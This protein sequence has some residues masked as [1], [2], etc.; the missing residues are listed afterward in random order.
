MEGAKIL[1]RVSSHQGVKKVWIGPGETVQRLKC[2][3]SAELGISAE[4]QDLCVVNRGDGPS[5][6]VRLDRMDATLGEMR[7]LHGDMVYLTSPEVS[8]MA[9]EQGDSKGVAGGRGGRR[10][11]HPEVVE[12]EVDRKL[13]ERDGWIPRPKTKSCDHKEDAICSACMPLAPWNVQEHEELKKVNLKHIPFHA[14]LRKKEYDS[15]NNP[16]YLE[17]PA[18]VIMDSNR[19]SAGKSTLSVVLERQVYRH[20]D[21]V[22]FE[23]STLIERFI[24][25][26]RQTGQQRCGHLFGHYEAEDIV[27]ESLGIRAV[28]SAIYEPPQTVYKDEVMLLKDPDEAKVEDL[29]KSLGMTRVGFIWTS[30]KVNENMEIVAERD[31]ST[32]ILTS[33]EC[34]RMCTF[35]N[36]YPS[37][38]SQSTSG[39]F[40]SKFVSVLVTGSREGNAE[41]NAYQMSNQFAR[42]VRDGVISYSKQSPSLMRVR[43]S[44]GNAIYPEIRYVAKNEYG[45]MVQFKADP[46]FPNEYGIVS[47]RHSFPIH[48]SPKFSCFTFPIEN[49]QVYELAPGP[50]AIQAQLANNAFPACLNDWH[51]LL[52]MIKVSPEL[53]DRF[54]NAVTSQSTLDV[55]LRRILQTS[56]LAGTLPTNSGAQSPGMN[57][58]VWSP[59]TPSV[60]RIEEMISQIVQ[61]GFSEEQAKQALTAT[62]HVS[63]DL[64]LD[65]LI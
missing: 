19:A 12:D 16:V 53:K 10:V 28:V 20:V 24:D 45:Y 50:L 8:A 26:W 61:L 25:A 37:P 5:R 64:A 60:A 22:E 6:M 42:L 57:M 36:R 38:C 32:F 31:E 39:K 27:K 29:A 11:L 14:W 1:V 33:K 4:T 21:H 47:V 9:R 7:V 52:Y 30:L 46:T 40:G 58:D 17:D 62:N 44:A 65:L 35:Q 3:I 49:R 55:D 2:L 56:A 54:V 13:R 34:I 41:V 51:F 15:P 63:V 59:V 18:C 43:E 23:S 48:P